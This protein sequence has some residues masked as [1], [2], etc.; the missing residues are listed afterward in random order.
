MHLPRADDGHKITC[1][2]AITHDRNIL[3]RKKRN[4][5]LLSALP[6]AFSLPPPRV[7]IGESATKEEETAQEIR[8]GEVARDPA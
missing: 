5:Y 6:F 2:A 7:C 4:A 3:Q 1:I 8:A